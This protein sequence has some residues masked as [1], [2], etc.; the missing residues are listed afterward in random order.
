MSGHATPDLSK[1]DLSDEG[2]FCCTFRLCH[3][4]ISLSHRGPLRHR[5]PRP[6]FR[7]ALDLVVAR[8]FRGI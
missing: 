8:P 1:D 3:I 6:I 4:L 5:I 7:C 2:E